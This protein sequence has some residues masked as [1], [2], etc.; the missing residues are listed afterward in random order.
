MGRKKKI[1]E[2]E[3]EPEINLDEVPEEETSTEESDPVES[4]PVE[5]EPE[6]ELAD[7]FDPEDDIEEPV[8]KLD[9]TLTGRI[10]KAQFAQ[11]KKDIQAVIQAK[12]K[13][14]IEDKKQEFINRARGAQ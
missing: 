5:S 7:E 14:N 13:K 6:E 1:E 10:H 9:D 8:A 2:P 12:I 3:T 11:T 4:D